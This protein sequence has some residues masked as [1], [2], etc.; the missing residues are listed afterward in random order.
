[1][2]LLGAVPVVGVALGS[3]AGLGAIKVAGSHV[4]VMARGT[5]QVFA[6]G[7]PVVKQAFNVDVDK[8]ALGGSQVHTRKSGVVDNEAAERF[9]VTDIIDPLET[10]ALL[11]DWALEAWEV[12]KTQ[13]GPRYRTLP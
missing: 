13:V 7:P 4:S 2:P 6:A 3:C 11:C 12:A 9:G 1:M 8:E 5:S 10:R